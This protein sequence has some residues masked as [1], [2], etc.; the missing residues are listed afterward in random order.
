MTTSDEDSSV[1]HI[2]LLRATGLTRGLISLALFVVALIIGIMYGSVG[3]MLFIVGFVWA[4]LLALVRPIGRAMSQHA[5]Q[6]RI[7]PGLWFEIDVD[8]EKE[9]YGPIR[10]HR[11]FGHPLGRD[12]HAADKDVK[13]D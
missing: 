3:L 12:H 4:S 6:R 9:R 13:A 5:E 8:R 10:A 11:L 7:E 1:K 2:R